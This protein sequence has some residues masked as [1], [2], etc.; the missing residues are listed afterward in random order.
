[1]SVAI[2]DYGSGNLHSA[3]KAFERAA[4][5]AGLT[6]EVTVTARP[7]DVLAADHVVLPGVGAFADCRRG[8]DGVS[9]MVEA[10]DEAVR[11]RG[12]PFLGICV[13]AQLMAT[14]GLEHE[15]VDGLNWI[16]G[17]VAAIKPS[18]PKL[19]IPHMG[20]NTLDVRRSH[21]LLEGVDTGERGLHAYFVHS[22]HLY[23]NHADDLVATADYGGPV[24]A[25]VARDNIAG[26]QFHPE[27]SQ[28][29]GLKLIANFLKWRP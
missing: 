1:M 13:G 6:C 12:K 18:D 2:I 23:A 20:W 22:Y 5:E 19:K 11:Q 28:T 16:A 14:R 3:R 7:E 8:L 10:M 9:G 17:D 24:T 21:A 27:K 25:I 4:R 26:T 29:L 15:V